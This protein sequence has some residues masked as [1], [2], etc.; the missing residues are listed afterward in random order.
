M[1]GRKFKGKKKYKIIMK[2][3]S[4]ITFSML[5]TDGSCRHIFES[6]TIKPD[7]NMCIC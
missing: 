5:A 4:A 6:K 3:F 7:G 1:S 2:H